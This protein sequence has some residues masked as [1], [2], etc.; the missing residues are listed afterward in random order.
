MKRIISL[1][2]AVATVVG[3]V[4]WIGPAGGQANEG[5]APIFVNEIP[6]IPGLEVDLCGL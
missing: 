5:T 6:R 1:L 2:V 4:A 3:V